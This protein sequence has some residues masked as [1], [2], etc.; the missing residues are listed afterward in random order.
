MGSARP[1]W[2]S[3]VE[4]VSAGVVLTSI[5]MRSPVSTWRKVSMRE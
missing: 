3:T 5:T 2:N 4:G 1:W